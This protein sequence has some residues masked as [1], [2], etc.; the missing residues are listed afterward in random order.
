MCRILGVIS[1]F[2][3]H[4]KDRLLLTLL[5]RIFD[6]V[7]GSETNTSFARTEMTSEDTTLSKERWLNEQNWDDSSSNYPAPSSSI[8]NIFWQIQ[9]KLVLKQ[10]GGILC[11]KEEARDLSFSTAL[12]MRDVGTQMTDPLS[13]ETEVELQDMS[14]VHIQLDNDLNTTDALIDVDE[15][16]FIETRSGYRYDKNFVKK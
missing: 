2:Y 11:L 3:R 12:E 15:I 16:S 1:A 8:L 10:I 13:S 5:T 6:S 7:R 14:C 4:Y 9:F